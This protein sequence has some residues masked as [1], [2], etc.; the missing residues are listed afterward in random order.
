MLEE[1]TCL[2]QRVTFA[3]C[4]EEKAILFGRLH[5]HEQSLGIYIMILKDTTGAEE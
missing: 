3:G 2:L 1:V 4:Y 5:R